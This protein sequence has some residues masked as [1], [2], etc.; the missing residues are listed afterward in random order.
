MR[1]E[2]RIQLYYQTGLLDWKN[3]QQAESLKNIGNHQNIKYFSAL[4]NIIGV[5]RLVG[6]AIKKG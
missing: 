4:L 6:S 2:E 5:K 3:E 1:D